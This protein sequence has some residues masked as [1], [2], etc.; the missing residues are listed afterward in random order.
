MLSLAHVLICRHQQ[1][2][3]KAVHRLGMC[4]M[5]IPL[6]SSLRIQWKNRLD[7]L[8][9]KETEISCNLAG[10]PQITPSFAEVG[11]VVIF[12]LRKS[13]SKYANANE[14]GK[15]G[16]AKPF[17]SAD[18]RSEPCLFPRRY[19]AFIGDI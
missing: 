13:N 14:Y 10:F 9:P 8:H 3:Y 4:L 2:I 17:K 5:K 6:Q 19:D 15:V 18:R 7:D 16:R 12:E 1:A 11:D